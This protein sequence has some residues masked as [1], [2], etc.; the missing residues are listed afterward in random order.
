MKKFLYIISILVAVIFPLYLTLAADT[1]Y[2]TTDADI[3]S[4]GRKVIGGF[5]SKESCLTSLKSVHSSWNPSTDCYISAKTTITSISPVSGKPQDLITIKGTGF[6]SVKSVFFS[7]SVNAVVISK[8][9]T[10]IKVM[11]PSGAITGPISINADGGIFTSGTFTMQS[12]LTW[13]FNDMDKNWRG[14]NGPRK[15]PGFPTQKDCEDS[16]TNY[17][18]DFTM[19]NLGAC[20]QAT[21]ADAL[22]EFE[23][24]KKVSAKMP[25]QDPAVPVS[26]KINQVENKDTYNLL[27][28]IGKIKSMSTNCQDADDTCISNNI[29]KYLNFIFK[30]MIGLCAALAVIMLIINGF[31]YMGD[32]SVFGKTEAKHKMFSAIFGLFIALAAWVIL[33]TINPDLVSTKI[34]I[35]SADI[36]VTPLYER[37][38]TDPKKANGESVRCTPVLSGPCSVANLTP[39]FGAENAVA[40]SK[41]CNMESSGTS[42]T[43]G[44]DVCKPGNTA[45]SFGLFQVNLASNGAL[46]GPEC[47]GLFDRAVKGSDA[48]E[49]KYS[50]GFTCKLLPG[51]EALYNTCKNKLLDTNTNLAIAKSLFLNSKG[52]HNW[53][54]DKRYCASAFN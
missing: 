13:W 33:N 2:Y 20:F 48:I 7:S 29:S 47:V 31:T 45:F 23:L 37:G 16:K 51:K 3:G 8:N 14:L 24:E 46:A 10:E 4:T 50:S 17:L 36:T 43:S 5:T 54:G 41:I 26:G 21:E 42:A 49:P 52:I 35:D 19:M 44:T 25:G 34:T 12:G 18:K 9:S 38:A 15:I 39:I 32:E 6:D 1:Y 27:A 11:V 30:F 40:M 53:D 28:P 22:N